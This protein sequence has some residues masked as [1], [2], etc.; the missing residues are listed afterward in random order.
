VA[1]SGRTIARSV[2]VCG[3]ALYALAGLLKVEYGAFV[4]GARSGGRDSIGAYEA[5][6]AGL[7]G[8]LP[9]Y[10][11]VAYVNDVKEHNENRA[12]WALTQY[13]LAPLIVVDSLDPGRVSGPWVV[14]NFHFRVPESVTA[15]RFRV[16]R[17][18]GNGV[19]L[20]ERENP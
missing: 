7:R 2:L 10:G 6:F 4:A 8:L 17:N 11:T 20:F 1:V 3:Y 16:I 15:G 18:F 13:A 5:R 12:A 14:G 19:F 9:P